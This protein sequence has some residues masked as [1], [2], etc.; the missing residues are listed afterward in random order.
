MKKIC[1]CLIFDKKTK[2]IKGLHTPYFLDLVTDKV[3]SRFFTIVLFFFIVTFGCYI[4]LSSIFDQQDVTRED[5]VSEMLFAAYPPTLVYYQETHIKPR[6]RIINE[7]Q[8]GLD[9]KTVKVDVVYVYSM[10]EFQGGSTLL[11]SRNEHL[12]DVGTKGTLSSK[13][14]SD[15]FINFDFLLTYGGTGIVLLTFTCDDTVVTFPILTESK[16]NK[17][18]LLNNPPKSN[19]Q[20]GKALTTQPRIQLFDSDDNPISG[21]YVSLFTVET[22]YI[23]YPYYERAAELLHH[24]QGPSDSDGIIQFQDFKV[25]GSNTLPQ[26]FGVFCEDDL[27]EVKTI[28]NWVNYKNNITN[29][30]LMIEP[31]N[32]ETEVHEIKIIRDISKNNIDGEAFKTQPKLQVLDSNGDGLSGIYIYAKISY[33]NGFPTSDFRQDTSWTTKYLLN[34]VIGP[35]DSEGYAEYENL[36]LSVLGF[37][38]GNED[39]E[40]YFQIKFRCEGVSSEPTKKFYVLSNV[41]SLKW[42]H[43][44][45]S[46]TPLMNNAYYDLQNL[47]EPYGSIHAMPMIKVLDSDGRGIVDKLVIIQAYP[48][49]LKDDLDLIQ[50]EDSIAWSDSDGVAS[51]SSARIVSYQSSDYQNVTFLFRCDTIDDFISDPI[52]IEIGTDDSIRCSKILIDETQIPKVDG[53][54]IVGTDPVDLKIQVLDYKGDPREGM[55]INLGVISSNNI[56]DIIYEPTV[57]DEYTDSNG[58]ATI[59]GFRL[60]GYNTTGDFFLSAANPNVSSITTTGGYPSDCFLYFR[61]SLLNPVYELKIEEFPDP[62]SDSDVIYPFH[63]I[64]KLIKLRAVDFLGNGVESIQIASILIQ[65]PIY[66]SQ[67]TLDKIIGPEENLHVPPNTININTKLFIN[68]NKTDSDGYVY[69]NDLWI[70]YPGNFYIFFLGNGIICDHSETLEINSQVSNITFHVQPDNVNNAIVSGENFQTQPEILIVDQNNDTLENYYIIAYVKDHQKEMKL[71]TAGQTYGAISNPSNSDGI[72]KFDEMKFKQILQNNDYYISFRSYFPAS[73]TSTSTSTA[74][75]TGNSQKY[76]EIVSNKILGK[77][78]VST[79]IISGFPSSSA[80]GVPFPSIPIVQIFG[81]NDEKLPNKIVTLAIT[82]APED[83]TE[84]SQIFENYE[85]VSDENGRILF[86]D[87]KFKSSAPLGIY[88]VQFNSDDAQSE[89]IFIQCTNQVYSL[90]ILIQPIDQVKVGIP[91]SV[92]NQVEIYGST[93]ILGELSVQAL[94]KSGGVIPEKSVNAF[95]KRNFN[96]TGVLD[97]QR[98]TSFTDNNGIAKFDLKFLA[99]TPA[100]YTLQFIAD[101]VITSESTRIKV[102]NPIQ[103]I[104]IVQQPGI[105]QQKNVKINVKLPQ[106]PIIQIIKNG[107]EPIDVIQQKSIT[108]TANNGGKVKYTSV[109][110]GD[111]GKITLQDLSIIDSP[112]GVYQLTFNVDGILSP[113]SNEIQVYN[114]SEPNFS[115]VSNIK[116]YIIIACLVVLL[117]FLA[118]SGFVQ[119]KYI[120]IFPLISILFILLLN[121]V[122]LAFTQSPFANVY[123][124]IAYTVFIIASYLTIVGVLLII[125]LHW[126]KKNKNWEFHNKK[127]LKFLNLVNRLMTIGSNRKLLRNQVIE[128]ILYFEKEK[129]G[130]LDDFNIQSGSDSSSASGDGGGDGD[131][132]DDDDSSGNGKYQ[133][134]RIIMKKWEN[135]IDILTNEQLKEFLNLNDIDEFGLEYESESDSETETEKI[136]KIKKI[137]KYEIEIEE[138]KEKEKEYEDKKGKGKEKN[139]LKIVYY[140]NEKQ[141]TPKKKKSIKK[142][143]ISMVKKLKKKKKNNPHKQFE[144]KSDFYYPQRILLSIFLSVIIVSFCILIFLK[145]I[146]WLYIYSLTKRQVL[147]TYQSKLASYVS[148]YDL[149]NQISSS[150]YSSSLNKLLSLIEKNVKVVNSS[151]IQL[152]TILKFVNFLSQINAKYIDNFFSAVVMC[153]NLA[154]AVGILVIIVLWHSILGEYKKNIMLLRQGKYPF[155]LKTNISNAVNYTSL[156]SWLT[157]IA[158]LVTYFVF[159]LV[160]LCF[161]FSFLRSFLWAKLWP[162][163]LTII[164]SFISKKIVQTIMK[165]YMIQFNKVRSFRAF[166]LF[167]FFWTFTNLVA[168]FSMAVIRIF[169]RIILSLITI[170]RVDIPIFGGF[171]SAIDSGH[172]AYVGVAMMD[173][174]H[175]NPTHLIFSDLVINDYKAKRLAK[176]RTFFKKKQKTRNKISLDKK[177]HLLT[178]YH[179]GSIINNETTKFNTHD[180]KLKLKKRAISKWFI[181]SSLLNN[182]DLRKHR[183]NY[184]HKRK[185]LKSEKEENEKK[186]TQ[187]EKIIAVEIITDDEF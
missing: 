76:L 42:I 86:K 108:I 179:D 90:N 16:V 20:F 177:E 178:D 141:S 116:S 72:A 104:E 128:K 45:T 18:K 28:K 63:P 105:L 56:P 77:T 161:G 157:G 32:F 163:L 50:F 99:A 114:P 70:G 85:A 138:E 98:V 92:T 169:V 151:Q 122:V 113:L 117:P 184:I 31:I 154:T 110:S 95:I 83:I 54:Y 64:N 51:F 44:P 52:E 170:L 136:M 36:R 53:R 164:I 176:K 127:K 91:F 172:G 156:Q 43:K 173:H 13:T 134:L 100:E 9:N 112:S 144:L 22:T 57:I 102:T 15:G 101:G 33:L 121:L 68:T 185:Q 55:Q 115:N 111:D 49:G 34:P 23:L 78:Q 74:M 147:L 61:I 129:R 126:F 71:L 25:I 30:Q 153:S 187:N 35:T 26:F 97:P 132:D 37:T 39:P 109:F 2:T 159:F 162:L 7:Y 167:D 60:F 135:T 73:S 6:I 148:Y 106:Q 24:T 65:Y 168:S 139:Q 69:I 180:L 131:G 62:D 155:E 165:K 67:L 182:P 152:D 130:L 4:A 59:K 81:E 149:I 10:K 79:I 160:F 183:A 88:I 125:L 186:L 11:Q 123:L 96:D 47:T 82:L 66:L 124:G 29:N 75:H 118:N 1:G 46:I 166:T 5:G 120:M 84:V 40:R 174:D 142:K 3:R 14:D 107:D 19:Q 89:T 8:V 38:G 143:I 158:Y 21:H 103:R 94:T 58:E 137:N 140:D 41:A 93:V 27:T 171:L 17:I 181:Y 119:K 48:D 80:P 133:S 150:E 87:L 146:D 175:N 12:L 145:L